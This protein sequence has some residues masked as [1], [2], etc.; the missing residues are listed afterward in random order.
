MKKIFL[1]IFSCIFIGITIFS[2]LLVYKP[3]ASIFHFKKNLNADEMI[4]YAGHA[5]RFQVNLNS[6]IFPAENSILYED[7]IPQKRTHT[8]AVVKEGQGQYSIVDKS[9]GLIY[10]NFSPSD[11]SNPLTNGK[12][13]TMYYKAI[14]FSRG[15][16]ASL[17]VIAFLGLAWFFIFLLKSPNRM[18]NL[19]TSPHTFWQA[20]DEFLFQE[21]TRVM[22]PVTN[23]GLL[24]H[25]KRRLW[26]FLLILSSAA[27]YFY[28]FMEWLFFVTKPSF[29]DLM[30]WY[31]KLELLLLP[32]F[33]LAILCLAFVIVIAGIDILSSQLGSTSLLIFVG[34]L[35]PSIILSAI[36]VIL[37]D[38]FTY[39]IFNFGI[40]SSDGM[41]RLIYGI[42]TL[43]LFIYI[44]KSILKV[45]G[46]R[47]E[48]E[49]PI[50]IPRFTIVLIT[51]LFVI[52]AVIT[53][54]RYESSVTADSQSFSLAGKNNG[55]AA[56][57]NILLIGSDGLNANNMS[58]YGYGRDTT[59]VLRELA[60]TS[61]LAENVFTNSSGSTGSI[62]SMLTGKSPAQTRV[63]NSH[64]ILHG[65]NAYQHLPGILN[66]EGYSTVELGV[67]N[68]IDAYQVNMLDGFDTVN[69]R[70]SKE[71]DV[72]RLPQEFGFIENA[73]FASRLFDRISERILHLSFIRKMENPY[74][75][76]TQ[77]V[78]MMYDQERQD[79]LLE[80]I[81]YS[82]LPLFVHVH[83]MGTHGP[84]FYPKQQVFSL[85][86]TQDQDD[87]I[88]FYDDSILDFDSYVGEVL[89]ELKHNSKL[90]NTILII[91][92][93]HPMKIHSGRMRIPLLIHFPNDEYAGRIRSNVQNLD[94]S[95]TILDYVGIEQPEWMAG[96]SLL[97]GDPPQDRLI[98]SSVP[99]N[100]TEKGRD[101]IGLD[102]IP[103][104]Y[105]LSSYNVINCQRWYNLNLIDL[106]WSFGDIPD[107]SS[108]CLEENLLTLEQA[109]DVLAEY[110]LSNNFD[111]SP[112]Q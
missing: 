25:S 54:A 23:R 67:R 104:S 92:S 66:K 102:V 53:V 100:D 86:M 79:K 57:P 43:I 29:M 17:L 72:I 41:S 112:H 28:V 74:T 45:M 96:Q 8:R 33:A 88:D 18:Q 19:R 44:N 46:L 13:Y 59:P 99:A 39:T 105:K 42:C 49:S 108:P 62:T 61:L 1:I 77:D 4:H 34:T 52:S 63:F 111:T 12:L 80:L 55:L 27:A 84:H 26:V 109:S 37:V 56:R 32:G 70:S 30:G 107:H 89:E 76:V 48:S 94:I 91:Y 24:P 68:Y 85:G 82:E 20:I 87:M 73:Y 97:N 22:S 50:A 106:T 75:I 7:G 69:D 58:V 16:G 103:G 51:C 35:I 14:F 65:T 5:Y 47:G 90:N 83:M 101:V 40:V 93:D 2:I 6:L 64:N 95:P 38:N 10:L 31:E 21:I 15:M 78:D 81:R 36:S 3:G 11:N 60:K 98:F 71:G 9:D 110:L